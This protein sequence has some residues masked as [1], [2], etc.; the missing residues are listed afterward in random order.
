MLFGPAQ[1]VNFDPIGG[2]IEVEHARG[3]EAPTILDL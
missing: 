3:E 1:K 2:L